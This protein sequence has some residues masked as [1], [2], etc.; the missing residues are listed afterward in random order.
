[1]SSGSACGSTGC[2]LGM[3]DEKVLEGID[4]VGVL[5]RSERGAFDD[6]TGVS[7]LWLNPSFV[8]GKSGRQLREPKMPLRASV[9]FVSVCAEPGS[10][11]RKA[12]PVTF[13]RLRPWRAKVF[14]LECGQN[15]LSE[16]G[17]FLNKKLGSSDVNCAQKG[18]SE[19]LS[20]INQVL[21]TWC[22]DKCWLKS[23]C[24]SVSSNNNVDSNSKICRVSSNHG[25]SISCSEVCLCGFKTIVGDMKK[26][27][28]ENL[29]EIAGFLVYKINYNKE[30][31]SI[32]H[33]GFLVSESEIEWV[34]VQHY[35]RNLSKSYRK[36]Q[37]L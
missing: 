22:V 26:Q 13:R 25:V 7:E 20:Y 36:A 4:G 3:L 30:D 28:I 15:R 16:F 31:R 32:K 33:F 35:Q 10:D 1:M 19:D 27:N 18:S 17:K 11:V 23:E 29:W 37:K 34:K 21:E 9:V 12:V 8:L 6:T 2:C 24:Q 14:G 5:L